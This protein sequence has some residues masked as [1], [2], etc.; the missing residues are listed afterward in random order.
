VEIETFHVQGNVYMLVGSGANVAVQT[1]D[2][3][4]LVVDTG[5]RETA[6]DVVAAIRRLS[7]KPIR[8][9]VNTHA[10]ADH[11][12]G[13]ETISQAGITVNGNPAAIVSHERTLARMS[14]AGRSVTELPLTTFFEEGRDFYFNGEAIFLH[15]VPRAHTDGD[16]LVYFRGSDVLVAGDVFATTT[17]PVIDRASDGGIEGFLGGLNAI[18]DITVPK[19]LQEGGTYVVP[20][21]GRV[22][23]EADVV[24]YRDMTLFVRDRVR[25]LRREGMTIA[26]VIAARP[27]LDYE[28][29]YDKNGSSTASF[30][31]AV[32][33]TVEP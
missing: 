22:A 6:A 13:N 25:A 20:G 33:A 10:H 4:V 16:V 17:F 19:Y 12:G 28:P 18:L 30:I 5:A 26:Q 14:D 27:A 7:E 11:T 8:W 31:E 3:G 24:A 1:G 29:R 15:H 9:I 21:H 23:D 2:D 32:Y